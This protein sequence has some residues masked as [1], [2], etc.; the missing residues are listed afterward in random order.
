MRALV[1]TTLALLAIITTTS[2]YLR[3][4]Q[5]GLACPDRVACYGRVQPSPEPGE[6]HTDVTIARGLHRVAASLVGVLVLAIAALGWNTLR[7]RELAASLALVV[8][9][10]LLAGLGRSTPSL[11]PAVTLG[12]LLGGFAMITV[13]AWLVATLRRAPA[14]MPIAIVPWL[15]LV[16]VA[17][18]VA[19]GGLVAA[20]SAGLACSIAECGAW[21]AGVPWSAFNPFVATIAPTDASELADATRQALN[22]AHRWLAVPV[23]LLVAWTGARTAVLGRRAVGVTLIV[24]AIVQIAVGLTQIALRLPLAVSL[25]HTLIAAAMLAVLAA[26]LDAVHADARGGMQ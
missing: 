7:R 8:L 20:R 25:I 1:W 16:L 23:V 3:L 9:A 5:A 6:E 2:A 4:T 12:N 11:L 15:A 24:L 14:T 22:I 19:L 13:A 10:G 21:P 18:E 26:A 17:L